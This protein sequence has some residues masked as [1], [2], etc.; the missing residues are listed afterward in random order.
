MKTNTLTLAT[1]L[2]AI[3]IVFTTSVMAQDD[4]PGKGR[5]GRPGK[6]FME[7]FDA[8]GDGKLSEPERAKARAAAKSRRDAVDTDG[9]GKLSTSERVSALKKR[10]A[11]D[12]KFAARFIER[13]DA[14]DSGALEDEELAEASKALGK[15]RGKHGAGP[16]G[17]RG[18]RGK[19]GGNKA[20][21]S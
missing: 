4:R 16:K 1:T 7:K 2:T 8:N 19:R 3:S 14:D 17:T 6:E 20:P 12:E 11:E 21:N 15:R 5:H 9:D 13:F 18:P 10:L